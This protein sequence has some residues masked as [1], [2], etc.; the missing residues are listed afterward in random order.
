MAVDA[1]AAEVVQLRGLLGLGGIAAFLMG[2]L[3]GL[4]AEH[5]AALLLPAA[6][7]VDMGCFRFLGADQLTCFI[8]AGAIM[9]VFRGNPLFQTAE[10][11][12]LNELRVTAFAMGVLH[13]AA[14]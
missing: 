4:A 1:L 9:L 11:N 5:P 3:G 6:F 13:Q 12:L 7:A 8:I 10:V 14:V 2:V